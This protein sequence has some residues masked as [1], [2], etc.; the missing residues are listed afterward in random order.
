MQQKHI[1]SCDWGTSS[2]RLHLVDTNA[3][4]CVANVSSGEG[5][6]A[7]FNEWKAAGNTDRVQFYLRYLQPLLNELSAKAGMPVGELTLIISGMASSTVG[8]KELPYADLPFK[9]DGSGASFEWIDGK[10]LFD[11]PIMLISG[12]H[13][14]DDVMRGE[15]TQLIG[16]A[17]LLNLQGDDNLIFILPG[18]HSKHI[19]VKDNSISQFKTFMTGEMFDI[20]ARHSILSHAVSEPE[21]ETRNDR[22]EI[23]DSGLS[24]AFQKGVNKALQSELLNALFS[25]RINQLKKYLSAEQNYFYLSGLLIGS[26]LKHAVD[27]ADQKLVLCSSGR[28]LQLYQMAIDC[29]G[30]SERTIT[31]PADILDNAA[32]AGQL[33]ILNNITSKII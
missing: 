20:I 18:T 33:K 28:L 23:I 15:E 13:Q 22:R 14:A 8:I 7:V 10:P 16:V 11:N 24:S 1:I 32:A 9:L 3:L 29:G 26:E 17:S 27:N 2:L 31:V 6:A 5:N 30:L 19:L 4:S 25:V 12:V 21:R